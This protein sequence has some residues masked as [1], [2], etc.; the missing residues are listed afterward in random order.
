MFAALDLARLDID[1]EG[2]DEAGDAL[3]GEAALA[4]DLDF[5][6]EQG[7]DL[8]AGVALGVDAGSLAEFAC[9]DRDL[10]DGVGFV[11]G[12]HGDLLVR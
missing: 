8:E 3:V 2:G 6:G 9:C 4:E 5:T 12:G 10:I 11:V 7:N 1:V